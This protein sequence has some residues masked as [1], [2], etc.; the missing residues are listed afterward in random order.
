MQEIDKNRL[1]R[2]IAIIMDGNGRWAK[3]NMLERVR[4][5]ERGADTVRENVTACRELG[6]EALSL[7]AFSEENWSRPKREVSALMRLL[8]KYLIEER[9]EIL[10]NNIRL[11]SAGRLEKLPQP[12]R[13]LLEERI[14]ESTKND[15]MFLNLCLS[16][17]GKEEIADATRAIAEKVA[18]GELLLQ[19]ITPEEFS[20]HLYLPQLP[21]VDLMIRTSGELRLSGFLLWQVAYAEFDFPEA[22]WPEFDKEQLYAAIARFQGRERRFGLTG[23]QLA[24]KKKG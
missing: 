10:D 8:E 16:Y 4:G 18:K 20:K 12:V 6:I 2:H 21:P 24:S 22:L 23:D 15:G 7:Y 14:A 3:R 13:G 5:H 9:S 1:P 17:S 11:V 19:D